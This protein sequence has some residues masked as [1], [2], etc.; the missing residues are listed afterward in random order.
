MT[1]ADSLENILHDLNVNKEAKVLDLHDSEQHTCKLEIICENVSV[2]GTIPC[3]HSGA[4]MI[5]PELM[6]QRQNVKH[7]TVDRFQP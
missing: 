7:D 5:S 3:A 2:K 6:I 1:I 4:Q